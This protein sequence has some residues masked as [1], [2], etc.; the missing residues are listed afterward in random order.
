MTKRELNQEQME[1]VKKIE[2]LIED[3]ELKSDGEANGVAAVD[4]W[5]GCGIC[6]C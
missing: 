4:D 3:N 2:T 5:H 1:A 6:C